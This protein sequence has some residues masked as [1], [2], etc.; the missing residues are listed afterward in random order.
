MNA[1]LGS[2]YTIK[3]W[4]EAVKNTP[5]DL[6]ETLKRVLYAIVLLT[7]LDFGLNY[8]QS[9]NHSRILVQNI[10]LPAN[11]DSLNAEYNLSIT[12]IDE[13]DRKILTITNK[14]GAKEQLGQSLT[15]GIFVGLF[16][17]LINKKSNQ[18]LEPIVKTPVDEVEAQSTQAHP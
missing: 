11:S 16:I 12:D 1:D 3:K 7:L 8:L 15:F 17:G 14:F 6:K 5:L 10:E 13:S 9:Q 18:R 2:D 4:F